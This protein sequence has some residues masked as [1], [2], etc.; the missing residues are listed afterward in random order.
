[1]ATPRTGTRVGNAFV[2]ITQIHVTTIPDSIRIQKIVT[3]AAVVFVVIVNTTPL[4]DIARFARIIIIDP[5][6]NLWMLRTCVR[7]VRVLD[8][9]SFVKDQYARKTT[10]C[11]V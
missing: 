6:V 1:M 9:E 2:T 7:P 4:G 3:A 11:P 5:V 10:L 8:P